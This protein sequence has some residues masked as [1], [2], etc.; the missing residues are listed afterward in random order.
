MTDKA[1]GPT[2]ERRGS[3]ALFGMT[4]AAGLGLVLLTFGFF[5]VLLYL[6]ERPLKPA[7]EGFFANFNASDFAAIYSSAGKPITD[8]AK[9]EE[10]VKDQ[11][12]I[13]EKLGA[14][15]SRTIRG[16]NLVRERGPAS[17]V[18]TYDATFDNG[19]ATVSLA[20][21]GS[22]EELKLVRTE[23]RSELLPRE[24]RG[25]RRRG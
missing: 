3:P 16:I 10:F 2:S 5:T 11:Q 15:Q 13:R 8:V 23:F 4:L 1:Q 17:T 12:L 21:Q 24:E 18:I 20:F 9:E 22:G 14:M 6:G 25:R 7:V 19:P